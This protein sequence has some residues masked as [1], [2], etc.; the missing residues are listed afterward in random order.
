MSDET[1]SAPAGDAPVTATQMQPMTAEAAAGL[2][3]SWP[4]DED[5][6]SVDADTSDTD[7]APEPAD[8]ATPE[9]EDG[10]LESAEAEDETTDPA[11]GDETPEDPGID[12][13]KVPGEA[14]FR[15]RDGSVV[16]AADLKRDYDELRQA[17]QLRETY[18]RNLSQFEQQRAQAAQQYQ[19]F[20]PVAQQAI[21]AIQASLPQVPNAPDP[22]LAQTDPIRYVEERA[23]YDAIVNDYNAKVGQMRQIQAQAEHQRRQAEVEQKQQLDR[24][25]EEQRDSLL[26]AMPDLR[27]TAKRQAFYQD[28]LDTG[29][30]VYGFSAGEL[31]N[32][33]DARLMKMAADAMAY[34][35]LMAKGAPKPGTQPAKAKPAAP[36]APRP[37]VAQG[38]KRGTPTEQAATKRERVWNEVRKAGPMDAR[39]AARFAAQL[40]L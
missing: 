19:Q 36:Q 26:K 40:D 28:F 37:A 32:V 4:D 7:E 27:D 35:K 33:Y 23:R 11:E 18:E 5:A 8:D 29:T 39:T 10:E 6:S 17:R 12:W 3:A 24:Y 2:L 20:L 34:R 9:G 25:I 31:N 21:Q 13:D 16:T 22:R 38:G 14:K 1:T 30:N 15:L